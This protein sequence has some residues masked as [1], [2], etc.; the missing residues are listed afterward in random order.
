MTST[1]TNYYDI[2]IIGAGIAGLYSAYN[3]KQMSP[4]SSFMVL[5]KYKKQWIGGRMSNEEFYGTTVV[6]GAGIGRKEKDHLLVGLLKQMHIK[7]SDFDI[8]MNYIVDNKVSIDKIIKD[9]RREYKRLGS[10]ITTFKSFAKSYLGA[11]EYNDFIT[12]VGYT[13]YENEDVYQTLY[14]YGMDDNSTG[15]TGLDIPW[16]QLIQKLV[17]T[18]G[19]NHVR[20]S[21]NV[22][23]ITPI[24]N[25]KINGKI[26]D[27][28]NDGF[29][30][31]LVT[32]KGTT[33]YCGKVIIATTITSIQKLLPQYK[34][35]N[36]IK[37]QPFL[38]LYAKFPKASAE[39]MRHLVPN[40]TIVSGP[41]QKII[42]ISVNKG[43]Y[44][45]AYS[46]NNNAL[47]L[48]DH[49]ENTAKNREFF[50][51][52]LTKTLKLP[53]NTLQITALLNFYWPVGT[54][55]YT[56]LDHTL[57]SKFID[58]AQH[59]MPNMLVVGEVVAPNQGW[60]EGALDS[61]KNVLTKQWIKND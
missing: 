50:C 31:E 6:T 45:I 18:I 15:W 49:L 17:H 37:S 2:I 51:D 56:P 26:N 24:I 60:T 29:G 52:L 36:H 3:I 44:M 61:V 48:K 43:V 27:K 55:Y 30:F 39:I 19:S 1:L 7:Y 12:N 32:E 9:L 59:P 4:N 21:N 23:S 38:R 16:K 46:D 20:S 58:K 41:L 28:I 57:R 54:H 5:E 34:I 8:N 14:K 53:D 13:D 35:Y 10:P 40:Y 47:V 11:K 25:G 22:V 42:P 33:Y